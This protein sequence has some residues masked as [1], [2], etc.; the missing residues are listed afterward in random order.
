VMLH[1]IGQALL[2]LPLLAMVSQAAIAQPAKAPAAQ[3]DERDMVVGPAFYV[4]DLARSL[5]FYRE[6]LGMEVTMQFGAD[7]AALD[8]KE[9]ARTGRLAEGHPNTVLSFG[10]DPMSPVIMLLRDGAPTGPRK[11]EH[12]HGYARVALRIANLPAVS[13]RLKAAGFE[14]T[15]IRGAHGTHQVMF[16]KDPDGYTVELVERNR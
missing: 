5:K 12:A 11:I 16:V 2:A 7:G 14:P 4:A 13:A 15:P 10:S 6:G 1:K 9:R 8:P 3:A